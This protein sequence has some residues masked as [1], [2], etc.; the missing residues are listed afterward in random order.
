MVCLKLGRKGNRMGLGKMTIQERFARRTKRISSGC[1]IWIDSTNGDGYG[2]TLW[3]GIRYKVHRLAHILASGR[4]P[5]GKFICHHCDVRN[6][7]EPTHLFVGDDKIN[8]ADRVS[9]G[10]QSKGEDRPTAKLTEKEVLKIRK[11]TRPRKYIAAE[12]GVA[13]GTVRAIQ[14]RQSWKHI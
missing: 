11:D 7:V 8:S 6:C 5:K 4:I 10:R 3:K 2:R 13:N 14:L 9:K 1:L 12:Y